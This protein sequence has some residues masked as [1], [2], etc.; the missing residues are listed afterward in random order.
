MKNLKEISRKVM[1]FAKNAGAEMADVF[2]QNL[3]TTSFSVSEQQVDSS[4][5]SLTK[6]FNLNFYK[7]KK[8]VIID[9]S[10]FSEASIRETVVRAAQLV[11]YADEDPF[12]GIAEKTKEFPELNQ[13]DPAIEKQSFEDKVTY[14]MNIEKA[15]MKIDPRIKKASG[16]YYEEGINSYCFANSKGVLGCYS[17]SF[18]EV[19]AELLAEEKN[20]KQEAGYWLSKNNLADLPDPESIAKK[21]ADNVLVVLGGVTP[22]TCKVPVIFDPDAGRSILRWGLFNGLSGHDVLKNS[23]FLAGSIDKQI[24]SELV[25]LID[26]P[27]HPEALNFPPFDHEGVPTQKHI[28]IDAGV[29]KKY[30]YDLYTANRAK[31]EPSGLSFRNTYRGRM[32]LTPINLYLKPGPRKLEEIISDV[33]E[34]LWVK[35]TIGFGIDSV[36]G[37]YSIGASGRWIRNGKLAEPVQGMT[38][39]A[40]LDVM[41]RQIDAVADDIEFRGNISVPSFRVKEMTISGV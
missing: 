3:R 27:F 24:A 28:F 7:D 4:E 13:I 33:K 35:S 29:V 14:A 15:A 17:S 39:A 20:A 21:A 31:A 34:G 30:I 32:R 10:D 12:N 41:L 26:D 37:G 6:G 16:V 23:S 5:R 2:V 22:K 11:K 25:T 38:I 9:S 18:I 19:S 1:E 8:R 40:P 36:T